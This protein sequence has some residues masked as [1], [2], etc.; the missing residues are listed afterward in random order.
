MEQA[1][2]L[3]NS[4]THLAL[5][6]AL[7]RSQRS[8]A[9]SNGLPYRSLNAGVRALYDIAVS[10]PRN[11]F[12]EI[13]ATSARLRPAQLINNVLKVTRNTHQMWGAR[14]GTS[15]SLSG[16]SR[17]Q[18]LENMRRNDPGFQEKDLREVRREGYQ[19]QYG[20]PGTEPITI[21]VELPAIW[22]KPPTP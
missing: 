8:A 6:N 2:V 15:T 13:P 12:D 11:P 20:S 21:R 18:V 14:T 16:G 3:T 7:S 1:H 17:E 4:R 19:F 5:W 10:N 22:L 9:L